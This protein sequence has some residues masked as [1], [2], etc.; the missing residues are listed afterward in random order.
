MRIPKGYR[1]DVVAVHAAY[2]QFSR[3]YTAQLLRKT[4]TAPNTEA[5]MERNITFSTG[6]RAGQVKRKFLTLDWSYIAKLVQRDYNGF[7]YSGFSAMRCQRV[8]EGKIKSEKLRKI[9]NDIIK[10]IENE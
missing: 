9:L 7:H 4:T 6:D 10:G 1:I 8:Y 3:A 5:E 2:P